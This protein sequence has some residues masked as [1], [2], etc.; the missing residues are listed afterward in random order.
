MIRHAVIVALL[1]LAGCGGSGSAPVP[2]ATPPPGVTSQRGDL[3]SI[4]SS[5]SIDVVA[6]NAAISILANTYG[7][8][9]SALSGISKYGVSLHRIVYKTVTPDGRLI[10]ASGVV[11]YPLKFGGASSPLLSYQHQTAFQNSETPS[12]SASTDEVLIA[13]A[14][15]GFI[16]AMPDYIGYGASTGEVHSYVHAQGLAASIVDLLRATRRLLANHNVATNGQLFLTGYSEGG[17]ATLAAQKEMEQNL[18][19][20]F[21]IT[22]SL[23]AAG[24]YDMSATARYI[25][26]LANNP[27]PKLVAFVFKAYDYWY[28]WNRLSEMFQLPY[29]ATIAAYQYDG[30]YLQG[31][32]TGDS[33]VLF[34]TTFRNNFLGSG[35]ATVKAAFTANNIY[36]WRPAAATRLFHGQ[37]DTVVPYF[38]ATNA[39]T[40]MTAAGSTSVEVVNCTTPPPG[41]RDHAICVGDYLSEVIRWFVPLASNL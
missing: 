36:N 26:G 28:G 32:L 13:L 8:N 38:N 29:S 9:T 22:A 5:A 34:N 6:V 19:T 14:G 30:N 23:P 37:D 24:P 10:D 4:T 35:E 12:Q 40:A 17:Y 2:G 27:N 41:F 1:L 7:V 25:V 11:A 15:S 18:P 20:E 16:V 31:P 39:V 3:V 33:T 21:P